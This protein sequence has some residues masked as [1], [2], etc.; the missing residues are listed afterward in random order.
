MSLSIR[1]LLIL[2]ITLFASE[3]AF[4]Q[5]IVI[6]N[7]S[8]GVI[9]GVFIKS[10]TGGNT[11]SNT[12][13]EFELPEKGT[14]FNFSHV[15]YRSK[16][17]S[18]KQLIHIGSVLLEDNIMS[19]EEVIVG[20]S[21]W[22]EK[23]YEVPQQI[24]NIEATEI[25]FNLPQTTADIIANSG[26]VFVQKSQMGGGSPMI[27]GFAANQV[28]LVVDGIRMNNAIY[29]GGNLQN[30]LAIDPNSIESAEVI[31]G[32]GSVMYGSDALGG[33][34]DFHTKNPDFTHNDETIIYGDAMLKYNSGNNEK[35]G[36]VRLNI[37][38]KKFAWNGSLTYSDF[39]DLQSGSW[40]R[41]ENDKFG[42]RKFTVVNGNNDD[43]ILMN[44]NLEN[45]TPS[46]YNQINTLQKF[47]FKPSTRLK[48]QYNFL[49]ST[50]SNVPRYDRLT[51]LNGIDNVNGETQFVT[52]ED[53]TTI[54][55]DYLVTP[56]G[57]TTPKF[58]EWYYGP[59]FWMMNSIR[60]DYLFDGKLADDMRII[61]GHQR[62]KEDRHNRKF[63]SDE[64]GNSFVNADVFNINI[65]YT[66]KAN[67]KVDL[68]YGLE[69]ITNKVDAHA[70]SENIYTGVTEVDLPRY[71]GG[72]SFYTTAAG[73]LSAK[74]HFS[75]KLVGTAGFRYTHTNI[76]SDYTDEASKELNLPYNH[77]NYNVGNITGSAG[78]AFHTRNWQLNT[79]FAKG[80][81]APNLDDIG[82]VYNPSKEDLVIP[83]P[84]L[85]PTDVYTIDATIERNIG[86]VVLIGVNA[87]YSWLR[88][89]MVRMPTTYQGQDSITIDNE[90]YA[91]L[92]LQN[93]GDA[94]IWG[95]SSTIKAVLSKSFSF[96][97]SYTYTYG[98][99]LENDE[100][101]R[102]VP[103][104][105][106]KV[107]IQY[108]HKNLHLALN[109]QYS[110]GISFDKL[111]PS[112]QAKPYLYAHTGAL[113]WWTLDFKSS[114]LLK[115]YLSVNVAIDN[116]LDQS[117]RTY[118]SGINAAGRSYILG[119][120]GFF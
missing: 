83:N 107:S 90:K 119:L 7:T 28:L 48:L 68:F 114:Y 42:Q 57:N 102:H 36:N 98:I 50:T 6:R 64:R 15:N 66:K 19:L 24:I 37:G 87:Y 63:K 78:L 21:K 94:R 84:D 111:A 86:N 43:S 40:Y 26:E 110:G 104:F 95:V 17:V 44:G 33:V 58:S 16:Q 32:P 109:N 74:Y 112:E 49:F 89:A 79:Q 60:M 52:S 118:S 92:S 1:F 8:G 73:Y 53:I 23:A 93:T 27:R 116:I 62:V 59:Q 101:L 85:K 115:E 11:I 47:S 46:A 72:G 10:D 35:T 77:F 105:F 67:Q 30:I 9:E 70:N 55:T 69:G 106:G 22:E 88:N 14:T 13:G 81:K 54:T 31:F 100:S 3:Y 12:N 18:R 41:S 4:T 5:T 117:Y 61:I 75:T 82:K 113:S 71:A 120:R 39:S 29:R 96:N 34:M 108:Q 51:E 76:Q 2:T 91:V 103:P 45:Q 97:A 99:D 80:F 56:Y 38:G 25:A 65:D 20:A